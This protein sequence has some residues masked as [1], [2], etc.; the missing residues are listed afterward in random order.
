MDSFR[1]QIKKMKVAGINT[2]AEFDVGYPTGFLSLDFLNG[3]VIHVE[4]EEIHTSYNSIGIIDGSAN[5]F[6][7]RSGCGKS[8]LIMQTAANIIRPYPRGKLFIDDIEGSLPQYRKEVLIGFPKEEFADRVDMRNTGITTE[9][10][11]KRI[12]LIHDLKI[13][14]KDE[15]EYD[16]GL[17]DTDGKRIFKLQPTT[18]VIDSLPMLMPED[19]ATEDE[20]NAGMGAAAIAKMNT[21]LVKKI[22][23]LLK[24][25]NIMLFSIN[26][27]LDDIQLNPYQRKQAPVAGLKEG[28]RLPGGRAAVYLANNMF[29]LDDTKTL[30]ETEG[31]G[32]DGSVVMASIVKSRSNKTKKAVPLIFNKTEGRFDNELSLYYLLKEEGRTGGAG[33]YMYLNALPNV[34]FAQKNFKEVLATNPEVQQVFAKE[35]YDVLK[36]F[37][38][39]MKVERYEEGE[40]P[41]FNIND[42]ILGYSAA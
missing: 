8:T 11:Y 20:I 10:V 39:D 18:Y 27:I 1:S 16:T 25:A 22:C 26:H 7:G 19:I 35:C 29:R 13:E 32:I 5:T 41:K 28:E 21:Q 3:C 9:N 2:T 30:K 24:E 6:I 12:K 4:T 36:T 34:K 17:Y 37:L 42:L 23:Q 33:S 15:F 38:S 14:N 40:Q 31:F